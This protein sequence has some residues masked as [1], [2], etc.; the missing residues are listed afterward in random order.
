MLRLP[1][2]MRDAIKSLAIKNNRSMNAEIVALIEYAE[3]A[4]AGVD[5]M[6]KQRNRLLK[7]NAELTAALKQPDIAGLS[8]SLRKRIEL[9]ASETGRTIQEEIGQAL[10]Q[11]FPPPPALDDIIQSLQD[12]F[13]RIDKGAVGIDPHAS[14]NLERTHNRTHSLRFYMNYLQAERDAGRG[15]GARE[16]FKAEYRELP[17]G[18]IVRRDA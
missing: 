4:R 18:S 2:G 14:E 13:T 16:R 3:M 15:E 1:D 10:E 12:M 6:L 11:A 7:E 8:E 9:R 5:D 17:D